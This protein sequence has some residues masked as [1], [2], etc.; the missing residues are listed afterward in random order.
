MNIIGVKKVIELCKQ[1]KKLDVKY[2]NTFR[3]IILFI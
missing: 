1:L 2:F 3:F